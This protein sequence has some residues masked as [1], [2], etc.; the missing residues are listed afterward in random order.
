[1]IQQKPFDIQRFADKLL[2]ACKARDPSA[3]VTVMVTPFYGEHIAIIKTDTGIEH[4]SFNTQT[5]AWI[6]CYNL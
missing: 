5:G 6:I 4:Y 2:E 1:M 3:E